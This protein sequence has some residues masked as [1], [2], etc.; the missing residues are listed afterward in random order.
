MRTVLLLGRNRELS[1]FR[2][3]VLQAAGFNVLL[4]GSKHEAL[5][6]VKT[7][8]F[9]VV[10]VSYSLS[11]DTAEELVELIRQ[12]SP[13]CP[14]VAISE[15]GWEDNKLQPEVTI[16]ANDGPEGMLAGI[17]RAM[18]RGLRRLK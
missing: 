12:R 1:L 4:P 11:N 10:L 13:N 7:S 5:E 14:V 9:D 18:R 17:E 2:V 16:S 3:H 6:A 8:S 15:T